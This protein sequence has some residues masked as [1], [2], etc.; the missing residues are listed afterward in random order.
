MRNP[1]RGID[2]RSPLAKRRGAP[3]GGGG[4]ARTLYGVT[5]GALASRNLPM[6]INGDGQS[7]DTVLVVAIPNGDALNPSKEQIAAGQRQNGSPALA[8]GSFGWGASGWDVPP[9]IASQSVRVGITVSNGGTL[10]EPVFSTAFTLDS[11]GPVLTGV[12]F[13]D[14]GLGQIAWGLESSEN[15]DRGVAIYAAAATP[16]PAEIVA[17]TGQLFGAT[18]SATAATP[19][20]GVITTGAGNF[21]CFAWARDTFGNVTISAPFTRSVA[22]P[23]AVTLTYLDG[24]ARNTAGNLTLDLSG[25]VAG[26][27]VRIYV[28]TLAQQ[29]N[30]HLTA[31]TV[32]GQSAVMLRQTI[33]GMPVECWEVILAANGSAAAV[34]VPTRASSFTSWAAYAVM[35]EG[36]INSDV[37]VTATRTDSNPVTASIDTPNNGVLIGCGGG[38][39]EVPNQPWTGLTLIEELAGAGATGR[40]SSIAAANVMAQTGRVVSLETTPGSTANVVSSLLLNAIG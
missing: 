11:N 17:G 26:K 39:S 6:D 4:P 30:N 35:I 3:G 19:V 2:R 22:A 28:Q 21:L 12:S 7:G 5:I 18:G 16:T 37:F 24:A 10:S 32:Q 33:G 23:P 20:S 15:G 34:L 8:A 36:T 29:A 9:G 1:V 14:N 13:A 38:E 31:L 27:R 25:A 40:R